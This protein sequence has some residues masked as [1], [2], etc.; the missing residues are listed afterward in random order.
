VFGSTGSAADG[1]RDQANVQFGTSAR[2]IGYS[3]TAVAVL[4]VI[5]VHREDKPG[6]WCIGQ[7]STKKRPLQ[8]PI[9]KNSESRFR[10]SEARFVLVG[11]TGIEPVT[12]SVSGITSVLSTPPTEHENRPS[13]SPHVRPNPWPLSLN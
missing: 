5:L 11:D 7:H 6:A 9:Q 3:P 4:V 12:S 10:C 13:T 2:V 1:A 8:N